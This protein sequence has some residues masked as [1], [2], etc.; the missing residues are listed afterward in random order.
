MK[1]EKFLTRNCLMESILS[2]FAL[3]D[4]LELD[5]LTITGLL[6]ALN[7]S[8]LYLNNDIYGHTKQQFSSMLY[9]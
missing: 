9:F 5:V 1:V 8:S 4:L 2:K 7:L 3:M 6:V